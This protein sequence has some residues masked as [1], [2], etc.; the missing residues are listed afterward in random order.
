MPRTIRILVTEPC[1]CKQDYHTVFDGVETKIVGQWNVTY[2]RTTYRWVG[3]AANG[4]GPTFMGRTLSDL[5]DQ[6]EEVIGSPVFN[7]EEEG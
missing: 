1:T 3:G 6:M 7:E 2:D 5:L 4:T